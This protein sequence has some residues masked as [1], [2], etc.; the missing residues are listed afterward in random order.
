VKHVEISLKSNKAC[1]EGAK[2]GLDYL[3]ENFVFIRD[4]KEL[5]L[6]EVMKSPKRGHFHTGVIKGTKSKPKAFEFEVPYKEKNLKGKQILQ[7]LDAWV[8]Y[9]TIEP[10]AR[11]AIAAVVKNEE[12]LD[13]SDSY[14]VLLGARSA[15]GPIQVLLALGA[16]VIAVDLNAPPI[17]ADLI[18]WTRDSCGT[19]TFPLSKKFDEVKDDEELKKVAGCNL[20][21]DTPEIL[22]WLLTIHPDKKFVVGGY[23]YLD[24]ER[25]VK[26]SITMDAIMKGLLEARPRGHVSLGFLCSP[27]DCFVIPQAA[28]DA[29]VKNRKHAPLWQ[30][31][32][33]NLAGGRF[34]STNARKIVESKDDE[35]YAVV[36]GLVVAQG[37][38]YALA[39]RIQH[40]RCIL[41]REEIG[42]VVST[43]VAPST[44]TR[45][46]VHNAQFAAAYGGMHHFTPMEIMYQETSNAVMGAL[47][48]HDIR[49]EKSVSNP[50]KVKLKNPQELFREGSFHGGIWRMG[51]KINSIG[52]V[53][54][55][56][57]YLK[58]YKL[59][60]FLALALFLAF[61]GLLFVKGLPHQWF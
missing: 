58:I 52:E 2:A 30:K 43:N 13:L 54:A 41:A 24:A 38:N 37:P 29:M 7:Q 16:N 1:I 27:T 6:E 31:M 45:S 17:W 48:I 46:V 39:K 28:H 18:A 15:M 36:D 26:L 35:T 60:L 22:D 51:Y 11:D 40:W 42:A 55:V 20:F 49:N 57:Y 9:G 10:S 14:F 44:A 25:F 21:S 56:T 23:A 33:A 59:Y 3:Y 61:V 47:L 8:D 50:A 34:L 4:E 32:I 19:L 53:A 5:K 12:W